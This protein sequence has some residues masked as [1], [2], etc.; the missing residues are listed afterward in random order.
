MSAVLIGEYLFPKNYPF[1]YST[2]VSV[3]YH[4][5]VWNLLSL[6]R[7]MET[8]NSLHLQDFPPKHQCVQ[9]LRVCV[10][11]EINCRQLF[12]T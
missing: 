12:L 11:F 5:M 2:R 1:L 10:T 3:T 7:N 6:E 9:R 4:Y 8:V